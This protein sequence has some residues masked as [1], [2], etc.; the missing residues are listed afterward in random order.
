[1]FFLWVSSSLCLVQWE[2]KCSSLPGCRHWPSSEWLF[3]SILNNV[4]SFQ[5][6]VLG[7]WVGLL[8]KGAGY[9]SVVTRVQRWKVSPFLKLS[10]DLTHICDMAHKPATL[11]V[12]TH[13]IIKVKW[14]VRCPVLRSELAKW[15]YL[16]HLMIS[17]CTPSLSG[18]WSVCVHV[19]ANALWCSSMYLS[20][21]YACCLQ[22]VISSISSW[23]V[24]DHI[25]V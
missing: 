1:M 5:S 18:D 6:V 14:R 11:T 21:K 13:T 23:E 15:G 8:N 19:C 3:C 2:M 25:R 10:S 4:I 7:H 12:R 20:V 17:V 9:V 16:S 22:I 24:T